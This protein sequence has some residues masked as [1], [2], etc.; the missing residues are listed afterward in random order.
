MLARTC[1]IL[2]PNLLV[3]L[4]LIYIFAIFS[5]QF[6]MDAIQPVLGEG[7][8]PVLEEMPL[9]IGF[10]FGEMVVFHKRF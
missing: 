2:M 6:Q 4:I 5:G 10:P 9:V 1:E 3:F 8:R 7:L